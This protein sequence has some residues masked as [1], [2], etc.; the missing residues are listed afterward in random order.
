MIVNVRTCVIINVLVNV[1][2]TLRIPQFV[3]KKKILEGTLVI[4]IQA[5]AKWK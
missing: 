1:Q 5:S 2:S 4:G 3:P